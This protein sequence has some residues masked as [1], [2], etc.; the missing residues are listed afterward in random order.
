MLKRTYPYELEQLP[1]D[2]NALEPYIDTETLKFHHDK[3]FQTYITNLNNILKDYKEYQK[4]ELGEIL[5]SI[6]QMPKEIQKG[7]Q[8]NAGGCYNHFVYFEQ[9]QEPKDQKPVG[10]LAE[11]INKTFRSYDDFCEEFTKAGLGVFGSGWVWLVKKEDKLVIMSTPNQIT[12]IQDGFTPLLILDVW[13]HAYYL[14][15]QNRRVE[16][17]A[18]WFRVIDWKKLNQWYVR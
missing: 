17:I 5:T 7:V 13:E 12:T 6:A 9:F 1:Y 4:M 14:K 10:E 11:A 15:H 2:Y 16:Y 18:D 8:N 3:H